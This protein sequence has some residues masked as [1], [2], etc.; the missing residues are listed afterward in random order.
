MKNAA[1]TLFYKIQNDP[2]L[3]KEGRV[4]YLNVVLHD[5]LNHFKNSDIYLQQHFKPHEQSLVNSDF[6]VHSE[7]PAADTR[8]ENVF[9]LLPKNMTEAKYM[10]ACGAQFLAEDGVFV[11]AADNKAGGTRIK[12][13]LQNFGFQQIAEDSRNKA[14]VV[15]AR[16]KDLNDHVIDQ[17]IQEGSKQNIFDNH[18]VSQ[19]GIFGWNKIDTGS[20]ILTQYLPHNIEGIGADFGCG[21]GYLSNYL[22][23]KNN[24]VES[25]FCIDA[26]YRALDSCRQNLEQYSCKKTYLWDDLTNPNSDINNMDFIIMNPPFHEGKTTDVSIGVSFIETAYSSLKKGGHLFMV[27][28][29]QLAYEDVLKNM[30]AKTDK[31]YEGN[32]FKVFQTVK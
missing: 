6:T 10:I 25:L 27:A 2:L 17:A 13:L 4:L 19:P 5:G 31:L 11:C 15:S 20:K 3:Y 12:K 14:R 1:D 16:K 7:L 29:R 22:L 24:D 26:D 21:Y 9:L 8:F 23:S 30:F 18:F 28:N 32:G